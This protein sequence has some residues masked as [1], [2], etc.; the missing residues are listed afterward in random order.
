MGQKGHTFIIFYAY[1][2]KKL[3]K[4]VNIQSEKCLPP[5]PH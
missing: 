5:L 1:K 3:L 4:R 2:E